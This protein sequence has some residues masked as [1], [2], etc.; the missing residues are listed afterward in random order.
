MNLPQG[1]S[2]TLKKTVLPTTLIISLCGYM[3]WRAG[4]WVQEDR[5]A[6]IRHDEENAA[7]AQNAID[8]VR[9]NKAE[10]DVRY[11]RLTDSLDA[12]AKQTADIKQQTTAIRETVDKILLREIRVAVKE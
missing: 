5:Q 1:I 6:F 4:Q 3:C 7:L 2:V 12:L 8:R 10:E 9:E 11:Q